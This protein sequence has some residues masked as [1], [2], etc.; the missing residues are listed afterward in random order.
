MIYFIKT[1]LR[2]T[3]TSSTLWLFCC[4]NV[5]TNEHSLHLI[6]FIAL[7]YHVIRSFLLNRDLW[8]PL[9]SGVL[10]TFGIY[11]FMRN[12]RISL[13]RFITINLIVS[14][15]L[16]N[17]AFLMAFTVSTSTLG[18]SPGNFHTHIWQ[19]CIL[20][21]I[22]LCYLLRYKLF[23]IYIRTLIWTIQK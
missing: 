16:S 18:N 9:Y 6:I 7:F 5:Q 3:T 13:Y 11:S 22:N 23:F 12:M 20:F 2:I 1:T 10:L 4:N 8:L 14:E 19:Y 17:F 15:R 21:Y